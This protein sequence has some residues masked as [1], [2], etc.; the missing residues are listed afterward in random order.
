MSDGEPT[1]L[2]EPVDVIAWLRALPV[3]TVLLDS[4]ADAWQCTR[5]PPD[6]GGGEGFTAF[7]CV[8]EEYLL[9]EVDEQQH[10]VY[11]ARFAPFRV[12]W[13]PPVAGG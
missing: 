9:C 3:G 10:M 6:E 4:G 5:V 13:T 1:E 12:L 8:P 7:R 11:M 2:T